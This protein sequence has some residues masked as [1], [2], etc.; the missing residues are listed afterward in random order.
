MEFKY[1]CEYANCSWYG[2]I[3]VI[4]RTLIL[5]SLGNDLFYK[6]TPICVCGHDCR[7]IT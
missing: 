1:R 5:I 7:Q 2:K 4:D 6:R 3:R